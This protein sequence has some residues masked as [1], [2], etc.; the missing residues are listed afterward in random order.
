MKKTFYIYLLVLLVA[1][2]FFIN[3]YNSYNKL[4]S[5]QKAISLQLDELNKKLQAT[6]NEKKQTKDK[7]LKIL[8]TQ[9]ILKISKKFFLEKEIG[10]FKQEDY[11]KLQINQKIEDFSK[12]KD[13]IL[14]LK[15]S[16][17][18]YTIDI[19]EIK[20]EANKLNTVFILKEIK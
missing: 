1:F 18:N 4:Q 20:K 10:V 16:T 5:T 17:K 11:I 7:L 14:A 12:L 13:L 9:E 15:E 19:I 3:S 6:I 2:A 8:T